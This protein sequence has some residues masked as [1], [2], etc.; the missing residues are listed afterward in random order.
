MIGRLWKR[1]FKRDVN[2]IE[3]TTDEICSLI[4]VIDGRKAQDQAAFNS[5]RHKLIRGFTDSDK[6]K[7]IAKDQHEW[8]EW[9][10]TWREEG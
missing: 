2:R 1:L 5:A 10:N 6:A 4:D 7:K 8:L 3:L 9:F